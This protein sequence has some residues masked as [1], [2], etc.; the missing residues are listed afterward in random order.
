MSI[1][2]ALRFGSWLLTVLAASVVS[3]GGPV[4]TDYSRKS[5]TELIDDL[6]QIDSESVA[7]NSNSVLAGFIAEETP[8]SLRTNTWGVVVL[9]APIQMRELVRR[10]PLA[11]P[12][13]IKHLDDARP[14][15]LRVGDTP[16]GSS[17]SFVGKLFCY[18]YAPR[19]FGSDLPSGRFRCTQQQFLSAYTVRVGDVCYALIGQIVNR[20]LLPVR[21]QPTGFLFVNS[22]IEAPVIVERVKS[23][24]RSGDAETV[25]ES[26]LADIHGASVPREES[27]YTHIVVNP[28]LQRLRLY[29]PDA[30]KAL[31]GDDLARRV[32]FERQDSAR[33]RASSR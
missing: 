5:V 19:V 11:L 18:E 23:D 30:Y 32:E 9:D 24:W 31:A 8:V 25:K 16:P 13:L 7:I 3:Y 29:F 28:A 17:G 12:E 15:K 10:G 26:L 21:V 27:V 33:N 20:R 4:S 6:T 2:A 1:T 22:P 14:T